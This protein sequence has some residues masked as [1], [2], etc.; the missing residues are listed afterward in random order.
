[1]T[2]GKRGR[3]KKHMEAGNKFAR[4]TPKTHSDLSILAEV[5][6]LSASE[7]VDLLMEP[8]R[9]KIEETLKMREQM[10]ALKKKDKLN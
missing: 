5:L 3:P 6:G 4:L 2:E 10:G 1:M 8:H 7:T 9:T